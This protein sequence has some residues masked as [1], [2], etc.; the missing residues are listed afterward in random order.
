MVKKKAPFGKENEA[1]PRDSVNA[2]GGV[3]SSNGDSSVGETSVGESSPSHE[4]RKFSSLS[5]L[6]V[7][8]NIVAIVLFLHFCKGILIPLVIAFFVWHL[9]NA[10]ANHLAYTF[11]TLKSKALQ[12]SILLAITL[13]LGAVQLGR[14][15]A[16]QLLSEIPTLSK[17][18]NEL[19]GTTLEAIPF[20]QR[21]SLDLI[22]NGSVDLSTPLQQ[23]AKGLLTLSGSVFITLL[24]VIF[25]FLEQSSFSSKLPK[26][27][28]E[29]D[30]Y[31]RATRVYE[32]LSEKI[33]T[34]VWVKSLI[35]ASTG[36]VSYIILLVMGVK[37]AA[38]WAL[39]TFILNYIPHIGSFFAVAGATL[40]S[41]IQFE[42]SSSSI[43]LLTLLTATQVFFGNI[44]EPRLMGRSLNLSPLV[45]LVSLVAWNAL[46]GIAGAFL[47]VP[48][49]V[50]VTIILAE[51]RSTAWVAMLLSNQGEFHNA[52]VPPK[53]QR[54]SILDRD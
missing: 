26:L 16:Y 1:N 40:F 28:A 3:A 18:W 51:F 12:I 32:S 30:S 24:Y 14:L 46:W 4:R 44:L 38:I 7:Q 13:I 52:S 11:P 42:H 6:L 17:R 53:N 15:S 27:W 45:I 19:L 37:F 9:V 48:L 47:A 8:A 2:N 10:L 35:S 50:V 41:F 33:Q 34:Y 49:M 23:V 39:L 54:T 22:L 21:D 43:L 20:L 31:E 25:L 36:L 5:L 29:K